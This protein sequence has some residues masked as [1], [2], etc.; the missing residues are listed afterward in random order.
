MDAKIE[1]VTSSAASRT[2]QPITHA[3]IDEPQEQTPELRGPELA[4]TILENLTKLDG[5]AHFTGNAPVLGRGSVAEQLGAPAPRALHSRP[6]PSVEPRESMT[7]DELRPLVAEVYEGT[8]WAPV[9]RILDD[10]EDRAAHPWLDSKRL[11]LNWPIEGGEARW[12]PADAWPKC[13]DG[14]EMDATLPIGIGVHRAFD[15]SGAALVWAQRQGDRVVVR[16]EL[17]DAPANGH[18]QTEQVRERIRTLAREFPRPQ[19]RDPKT[20]WALRGPAIAF[21]RMGFQESAETLDLEGLNLV[22]FPQG[23]AHMGPATTIAYEAIVTGRLD[24]DG[25]VTMAEHLAAS[26]ARTTERGTFV[27]PSKP[28]SRPN[29]GAVALV[30]AVAMAMQDAPPPPRPKRPTAVGF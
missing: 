16:Q 4:Q 7:R 3:L 12:L 1:R 15:G 2:G 28:G 17:F 24:H 27:V 30:M 11:F 8:P 5:W 19:M 25:A 14:A 18:I 26:V 10:I 20:R 23:P 9:E 22:D 6:R 13:T 29:H 21:D